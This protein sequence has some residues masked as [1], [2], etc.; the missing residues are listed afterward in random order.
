M[1][2]RQKLGPLRYDYSFPLRIGPAHHQAER[3]AYP[4]HVAQM[5]RQALL[6][7]PGERV[8][9]PDFGCGLR[10]LLFAPKTTGLSATVELMIHR[11][12]DKYLGGHIVIAAVKVGDAPDAGDG[13]LQ[14][15]VEYTLIETQTKDTVTLE[16]PIGG[17]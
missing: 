7:S 15:S 10:Q 5:V 9:M 12:L 14:I 3:A 4:E 8:C 6:T 17:N 11:T 2:T 13:A 16:V 1:A